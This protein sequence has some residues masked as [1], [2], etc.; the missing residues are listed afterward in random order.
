MVHSLQSTGG[1]QAVWLAGEPTH[2][3]YYMFCYCVSKLFI[4]P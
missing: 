1:T 4:W 2:I 3:F